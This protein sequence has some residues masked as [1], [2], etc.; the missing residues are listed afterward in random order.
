VNY[1]WHYRRT[2]SVGIL[3]RVLKYLLPMPQLPTDW[4]S[5]IKCWKYRKNN[6]VSKVLAW[7]K[8]I[9]HSLFV[10]KTVGVFFSTEVATEMG[11]TDNQYSNRWI[12]SVM[13]SVKKILMNCVSY[14]NG[15]NLSVKLFNGVVQSTLHNSKSTKTNA[16]FCSFLVFFF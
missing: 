15:N 11:I 1:R 16:S 13:L 14:T 2:V 4:P 7:K 10:C 12:P 8:K 6:S 5:V 9:W 3:Q